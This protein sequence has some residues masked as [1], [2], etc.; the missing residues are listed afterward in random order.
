MA[1]AALLTALAAACGPPGGDT[2][3]SQMAQDFLDAQNAVRDSA[4]PPPSPSLPH[5]TWSNHAA[6]VAEAWAKGCAYGHNAD[7]GHLGENI[8]AGSP[9]GSQT[10]ADVVGLWSGEA[11]NYDYAANACNGDCLHYTQL[12]W[13]ATVAVGCA[14]A[15]CAGP[16]SPFSNGQSWDFWVCDYD[17]PGNVAGQ[18]PY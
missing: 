4:Q 8:A 13:R 16:T 9:A 17:P 3:P 10:P 1:A 14:K 15:T 12:V 11:E 2:P 6:S 7:R 5:L 18:K